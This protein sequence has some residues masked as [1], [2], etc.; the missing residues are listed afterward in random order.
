MTRKKSFLIPAL[1]ILV[2]GG[3][4]IP[5]GILLTLY[6]SGALLLVDP[7]EEIQVRTGISVLIL[8]FLTLSI[9]PLRSLTGWN[10]LVRFRRL[11][12]TFAFFYATLHAFSYFVFDQALSFM[13]IVEDVIEHPWVLAGF[14]AFLLLIPLALTSTTGSIR[15]LGGK[16][17]RR[18]HAL[19]YPIAMLGVLHFYWLVK[20]DASEPIIY[21]LILAAILGAR[22]L[23]WKK[24]KIRSPLSAAP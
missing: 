14:S 6:F 2:W 13:A 24:S 10:K 22:L 20:K 19:V 17:W 23:V 1:K 8:L 18:L 16:R 21:A 9:T 11:L 3:A 7:V 4:L 12:G 15:R 5:L